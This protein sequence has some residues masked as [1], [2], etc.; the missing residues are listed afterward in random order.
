MNTPKDQQSQAQENECLDIWTYLAESEDLAWQPSNLGEYKQ[1]SLWKS[2]PM[3][4]EFSDITSQ[5]SPS[6][7]T[8]ETTT[9]SQEN[10][11]SLQWDGRVQA[12]QTQEI[13]QDS[14]IQPHH[15]GEK[16]LDVSLKLNP[17]S[18]LWNNLKALSDEDLELF[19]PASIWQ[20]TVLRLKQS[21]RESLGQDT[22]DDEFLSFPTLTSNECSTSRPAGQTKCEK[23]FKDKG[24]IPSGYQLGTRAIAN[25]MG[26]PSNWFEVLSQ[27]NSNKKIISSQVKHQ[28]ESEQDTWQEEQ[29]HQDKQPLPS[30]E[31][32]ISIPCLVKQ[33]DRPEVKGIIQKDLGDR[34]LVNIGDE[35]ITV[36][37]LF[38]YPDFSKSVGQ[39]EKSPRKKLHPST[40]NPRKNRRKNGQGNGSIYYRTVTKNRKEY[41]EA[42]YHYV[43]NGK[44]RTKYI[45]KK[46]LDKVQEAESLK[47]PV[48]EI[49]VLLGGDKKN[50]RK[51]SS[52]SSICVDEKLNDS[53]VEQV[54]ETNEKNPRKTTPPSTRKRKQGD[55]AGYIECKPIKRSGKEYKQ[56]WYHWEIWSKGDRLTKKSKYIPKN[57]RAQIEKMNDEKVPVREILKVLQS[58]SKK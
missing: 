53:C 6:I 24:L 48:S 47:L 9:Q 15:S 18:V 56:Y 13:K 54:L 43:E 55:G 34:F 52:T 16:D 33:P 22:R 57:K 39:I 44:K 32:S 41:R 1:L 21:R 19:L 37:K 3:H 49:L 11:T 2:T 14:N 51:N 12:H 28:D 10:L 58:K 30:V 27:K 7:Q 20:D 46:L 4:S 5:V 8:S 45:P 40:N 29:L 23:W 42:Y 36:S 17:S 26:F 31:S 50:P 38:V 35:A 25:I